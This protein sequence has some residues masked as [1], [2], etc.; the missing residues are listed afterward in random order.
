MKYTGE[1]LMPG[2]LNKTALEH[3]HRYAICIDF[4]KGKKVLDI[5]SGEGYGSNLLAN[6]AQQVIG[7]DISQEAILHSSLLYKK[8][9]LTFKH[10]S[11]LDIPFPDY[12]FDV[13]VSFE[14]LEHI[15]DH[16]TTMSEFRRVL[17]PDGLLI[18]STPEKATYS[19]LSNYI[20]PFHEKELYEDEFKDLNMRFFQFTSFFYQKFLK[21]SVIFTPDMAIGSME[22]YT[23]GFK[24]LGAKS[25]FKK[26]YIVA[27]SSNFPISNSP[28]LSIFSPDNNEE[29]I[30]LKIMEERIRKAKSG[31]RYRFI[32]YVFKPYDFLKKFI[33]EKA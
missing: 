16:E 17:K 33:N 28:I 21:G 22:V 26:E 14:T 5:A 7:V 11:I 30:L 2:T 3:L 15:L 12:S 24:N 8:E 32:D 10:G 19:D 31:F 6:Y 23:G 9:N 4:V 18:I 27:F 1:R 29:E 20:N 13:V 25:D